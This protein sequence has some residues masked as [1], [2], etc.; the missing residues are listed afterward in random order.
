MK[1]RTSHVF[2]DTITPEKTKFSFGNYPLSVG[3]SEDAMLA[4][5]RFSTAFLNPRRFDCLPKL[6]CNLCTEVMKTHMF[7]VLCL[8]KKHDKDKV[9]IYVIQYLTTKS[10]FSIHFRYMVYR[11][12]HKV[13][14]H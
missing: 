14:V 7:P 13:S 8:V 10:I 12:Y 2:S 6:M 1:P 4:I 11:Y 9:F 3:R 5:S